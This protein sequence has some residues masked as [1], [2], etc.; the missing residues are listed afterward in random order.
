MA[1][2]PLVAEIADADQRASQSFEAFA[3]R[4]HAPIPAA[5]PKSS[6]MAIGARLA[7]KKKFNS[8]FDIDTP[9]PN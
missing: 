8:P 3:R 6:S 2:A 7:E 5:G 1:I 4:Q 9:T